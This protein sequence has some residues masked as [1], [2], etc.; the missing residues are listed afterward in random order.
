MLRITANKSASG[1][2]KYFDEGLSKSDY[3]SEKNE[4]TGKWQGKTAKLLGLKGDVK[5]EEFEALAY[6]KNPLTEKQLTARNSDSRRVGYDFTFDVP[7]SVSII[8]SQTKDEDILHAFDEAV[9]ETMLEIEQNASTRVRAKGRNENRLTGNLVWGKF[10]HEDARPVGGIPDPHLHQHVFVFNATYDQ[11]EKRFK[12][13]QFGDIKSNAPYFEAVFHSRLADK[14][15]NVGYQIER[16]EKHFEVKGFERSTIDKFSNRTRQINQKAEELKVTNVKALDQLGAKTRASKR[17]GYDKEDLRLQWR[18]RLSEKEM[19]LVKNAKSEPPPNGGGGSSPLSRI[20]ERV[21]GIGAIAVENKKE[22]VSAK[23]AL[24]YAL[25]HSLER[26]SVISEKELLTIGLQRGIGSFTPEELRKE[27]SSKEDLL[28]K[29]D[30]KTGEVIFT[31]KEAITEERAL[32]KAAKNGKNQFE[33]VNPDYQIKN[34]QLT[35]EQGGAVHHVLNSKD[36]ITVVSGGAGTGKTW[37]IKEVAEGIK[38]KGVNFGAFAPSSSASREV[39][40]ADGFDN[41]T[42][43]AELLISK[44]LQESVK[45]GW[46]WLDEGG[47]IGNKT[48]NK[49]INIAE[50]QNARILITGDIKQHASVERGDALRILQKFGGIKPASISKIQRQKNTDY[51]SAIK[52]LSLGHIENGFKALDQMGAIKESDSL[53]EATQN[54]ANEYTTS[55]KNKENVLIVATTHNQGKAV[56]EAIRTKLKDEGVLQGNERVF[57]TQK[58]LSY[59]DAQKQDSANYQEGMII[60]FRQNVKGGI[61]RDTK[62][63]VL[64]KDEKGD[65]SIAAVN[66]DEN[67]KGNTPL[68]LPLKNADKFSVY[69]SETVSLAKGDQIRITQIGFSNEK[70]RLNTGNILSVKGFDK[71]GN[72][73][74][75]TGR[76]DV[77]L[78]KNF[79]NLTHGY[80]TT[81]PSAQGKS[82]NRVIIMQSSLSGKATSKEQFY[83]S[84]SR[85]KFAISIHTDDKESLLRNVQRSSQRMTASE[86]AQGI[87][88]TEKVMKDKLKKLGSLYRAGKSKVANINDKWQD[89]KADIISVFSKPPKPVKSAPIRTK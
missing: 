23:E 1:A 57:K 50:E 47:M 85:G 15:Q 40:R 7:K 63:H 12:A 14:L 71:K 66:A 52:S 41:A 70:K 77:V 64:G 73:I 31:T 20:A 27:L 60:Q 42:T 35:T 53:E 29:K 56:T 78:D 44:K 24:D 32:I 59:T 37:S 76:S 72:I 38:E 13:A 18:S 87:N 74:A 33:P 51:R 2:T 88:Q 61:K 80:Y 22:K 46:M 21:V 5:R 17:T 89:K 69:Q 30:V 82:V 67:K 83:V 45:D 48:M 19:E 3:Y 34:E 81:S 11:K 62:Y 4:I 54:I 86:V 65:I 49:V 68:T 55:I 16:N 39:Q 84:T 26:K 25:N 79:G 75:S 6:N 58:K 10:T 43:V 8:Y 28:S 9:N 36:F